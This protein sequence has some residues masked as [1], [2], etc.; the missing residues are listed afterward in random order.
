M[1]KMIA[2]A[3]LPIGVHEDWGNGVR[4]GG[5][6]GRTIVF[7]DPVVDTYTAVDRGTSNKQQMLKRG[8]DSRLHVK[9]DGQDERYVHDDP[10][11]R[12]CENEVYGRKDQPRARNEEKQISCR[13][14]VHPT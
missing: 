9:R 10:R 6:E 4:I 13:P 8:G 11:E 1:V 7:C 12:A 3:K 2:P 5:G 14:G